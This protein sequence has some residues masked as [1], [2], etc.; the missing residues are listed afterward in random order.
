MI[1]KL[2]APPTWACILFLTVVPTAA[3]A[4]NESLVG[5]VENSDARFYIRAASTQ[6][7]GQVVTFWQIIDYK[8]PRQNK[9]GETYSSMEQRVAIDC[10]ASSQTQLFVKV[11]SEN[12]ARGNLIAQGPL[13]RRDPIPKG[14]S[15]EQIRNFVCR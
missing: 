6:R 1:K 7:S 5:V 12:L 11:Y 14:T 3:I 10:A 15:L 8:R 13:N 4:A 2:R 9:K